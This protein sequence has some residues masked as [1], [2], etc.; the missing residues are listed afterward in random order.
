M[1]LISY[2][3]ME[4]I[5]NIVYVVTANDLIGFGHLYRVL[6]ISVSVLS[7]EPSANILFFLF[8][9]SKN[10][11]KIIENYYKAQGLPPPFVR[12]ENLFSKEPI[13]SHAPNLIFSDSPLLSDEEEIWMKRLGTY[14]AVTDSV[15]KKYADFVLDC[16]LHEISEDDY[17]ATQL[18][19]TT[20]F[21][22]PKYALLREEFIKEDYKKRNYDKLSLNL[23]IYLGSGVENDFL[24]GLGAAIRDR[25]GE[26]IKI[27]ILGLNKSHEVYEHASRDGITILERSN[28][29][30]KLYQIADFSIGTCGISQWERMYLGLPTLNFLSAENQVDDL[31]I[32]SNSGVTVDLGWVHDYVPEAMFK[33]MDKLLCDRKRLEKMELN[34]REFMRDHIPFDK[35][36][37]NEIKPRIS[38]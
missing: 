33:E 27:T 25:Y 26:K 23:L 20:L 13:H 3:S 10:A 16:N 36:F 1:N 37:K 28:S 6:S 29:M 35:I 31:R 12:Q 4:L 15:K 38:E 30:A 2:R 11:K 32:L 22:G 14:F 24:L 8:S 17:K 5:I 7:S 21:Y 9:S 19:G 34:G 18:S